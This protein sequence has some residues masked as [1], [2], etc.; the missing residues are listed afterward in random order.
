MEHIPG[1]DAWITRDPR[2]DESH[3][4]ECSQHEDAHERCIC[5]CDME[6]HPEDHCENGR[7]ATC[8]CDGRKLDDDPDC[9]C[10]ELRADDK[11]D[12]AEYR[13]DC[14]ADR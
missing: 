9:T 8:G 12:A 1:L 5:G 11:A 10:D 7:A 3:H 13:A 4:P 6:G 2:E 14:R